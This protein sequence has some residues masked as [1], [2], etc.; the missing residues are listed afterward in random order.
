[1][2]DGTSMLL[3]AGK[4]GVNKIHEVSADLGFVGLQVAC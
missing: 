1:M 4:D 3:S 2:P